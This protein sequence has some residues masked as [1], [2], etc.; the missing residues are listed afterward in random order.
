M[1]IDGKTQAFALGLLAA[2]GFIAALS[3]SALPSFIPA[4]AG[5]DIIRTAGIAA[6]LVS[7]VG[8]AMG[9]FSSS[10]P[11]PLAPQDPPVVAAAT[12]LHEVASAPDPVPAQVVRAK[13]DLQVAV[14]NA[15]APTK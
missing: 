9:L 2:L 15:T 8:A 3:P 4:G 1:Q 13:S 11:G 14:A 12:A 7:T 10:K 6:G 5:A